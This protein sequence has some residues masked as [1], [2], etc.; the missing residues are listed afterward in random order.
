MY[1]TFF[2][3]YFLARYPKWI[4]YTIMTATGISLPLV[5]LVKEQ[6]N[7]S[8]LDSLDNETPENEEI[9][10]NNDNTEENHVSPIGSPNLSS[11]H[12]RVTG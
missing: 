5:F 10:E 9:S 6:Y 12:S 1:E 8:A 7:R 11:Y 2:N 3:F 4:P